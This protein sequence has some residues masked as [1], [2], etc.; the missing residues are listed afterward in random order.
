MA[1]VENATFVARL[2][3]YHPDD[4]ERLRKRAVIAM[5]RGKPLPDLDAMALRRVPTWGASAAQVKG[6]L[7]TLSVW[8]RITPIEDPVAAER[9]E[10]EAQYV[11]QT[12]AATREPRWS[13]AQMERVREKTF[14]QV[15]RAS[16]SYAE[17]DVDAYLDAVLAAMRR[18]ID[19]PAPQYA[20]FD[21]AGLR[22]GYDPKE[23]DDFLD[24][25]ARMTPED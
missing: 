9:R 5:K 6:L 12:A 15:V 1:T 11:V 19:L 17:A 8:A 24:E 7:T 2:G 20:R 10:R 3:G 16:V 14:R 25:I 13:R 23:V 4:V 21:S 18:G 22:R